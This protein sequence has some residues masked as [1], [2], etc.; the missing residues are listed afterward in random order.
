MSRSSPGWERKLKRMRES[1][2][3]SEMA[4]KWTLN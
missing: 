1:I 3:E 4:I 2:E